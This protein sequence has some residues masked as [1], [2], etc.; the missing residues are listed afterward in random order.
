[1]LNP[2]VP[3]AQPCAADRAAIL[4]LMTHLQPDL[5]AAHPDLHLVDDIGDGFHSTARL[6]PAFR[7]AKLTRADCDQARPEPGIELRSSHL[8]L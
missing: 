1:M 3:V 7:R 2:D 5:L 4:S 8:K 6:H